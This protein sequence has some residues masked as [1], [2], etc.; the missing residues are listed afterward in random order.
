MR[1]TGIMCLHFSYPDSIIRTRAPQ[2]FLRCIFSQT[3][4]EPLTRTSAL[5]MPGA[6][7]SH[8]LPGFPVA[9]GSWQRR[10]SVAGDSRIIPQGAQASTSSG[11]ADC[12]CQW[13]QPASVRL[14]A[15]RRVCASI[16]PN[17]TPSAPG[18]GASCA[19]FLAKS[20]TQMLT[21]AAV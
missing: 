17:L 2:R 9:E 8:I 14:S 15:G 13:H 4:F 10:V 21:E 7:F 18:L 1:Q 12:Q 16:S 20:E 19:V 5:R 3:C 11:D 6:G